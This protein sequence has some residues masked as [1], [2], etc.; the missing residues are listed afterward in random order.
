MCITQMYFIFANLYAYNISPLAKFTIFVS[1]IN[2]VFLLKYNM[3][4]SLSSCI[5]SV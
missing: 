3:N 4:L 1:T 2:F 5:Q